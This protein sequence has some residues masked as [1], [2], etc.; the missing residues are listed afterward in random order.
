MDE[1]YMKMA[2]DEAKKGFSEN[3]VPIGAVIVYKDKIIA[4]AHNKKNRCN[5]PLY[6]AELLAINEACEYLKNWRL[7]DCSIYVT[8]EPCPMC[9]SAIKQSRISKLCYGVSAQ[10]IE[11]HNLSTSIVEST[12]INS[13]V[14]IVNNVLYDE[15]LE[16]LQNFF[17]LRR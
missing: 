1:K 6:H 10:N 17:K 7:D 12:D 14:M 8:L 15:C 11:L 3:E 5:N 4:K 16:L 2:L 13:K 9:A